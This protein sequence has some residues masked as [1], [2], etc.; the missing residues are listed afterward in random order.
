MWQTNEIKIVLSTNGYNIPSQMVI[1]THCGA[2][3]N[4]D[5]RNAAI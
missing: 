4:Y 2:L 3:I 1:T 5:N